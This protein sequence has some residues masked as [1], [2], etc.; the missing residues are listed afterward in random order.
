MEKTNVIF[1]PNRKELQTPDTIQL[2]KQELN[3]STSLIF[4]G[5]FVDEHLLSHIVNLRKNSFK[6][7]TT[8]KS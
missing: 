1:V 7:V 4:L 5:M 3:V 6:Y 2:L 8:L